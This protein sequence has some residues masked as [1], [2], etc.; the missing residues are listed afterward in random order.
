MTIQICHDQQIS[1][2]VCRN[3]YSASICAERGKK[4]PDGCTARTIIVYVAKCFCGNC[5]VSGVSYGFL[6]FPM[7]P[8]VSQQNLVWPQ[9]LLIYYSSMTC[10]G[11]EHLCQLYLVGLNRASHFCSSPNRAI[12]HSKEHE[13]PSLITVLVSCSHL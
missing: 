6:W 13:K 11:T 8:C 5:V 2:L 9:M 10:C 4:L 1:K 3:C 12:L 7:V